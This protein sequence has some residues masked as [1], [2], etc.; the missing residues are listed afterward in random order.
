MYCRDRR[1][2][3]DRSSERERERER[4]RV[5]GS[6]FA[7]DVYVDSDGFFTI[8]EDTHKQSAVACGFS[9]DS[10]GLLVVIAVLRGDWRGEREV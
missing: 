1:V 3:Y 10:E 6:L 2:T 5:R 9:V 7:C 8:E 4:E